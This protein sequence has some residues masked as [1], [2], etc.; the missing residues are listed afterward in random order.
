MVVVYGLTN[1][2]F[3][4]KYQK[5]FKIVGFYRVPYIQAG[6]PFKADFLSVI[7]LSFN[8]IP[9]HIRRIINEWVY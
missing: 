1:G 7:P 9:F 6:T 8:S 2:T 3:Q 4:E 5:G